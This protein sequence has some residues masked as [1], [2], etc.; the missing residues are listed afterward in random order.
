MADYRIEQPSAASPKVD[1][2]KDRRA[3]AYDCDDVE[4]AV[5]R[6]IRDRGFDREGDQVTLIHPDGYPER[7]KIR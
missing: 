7:L 4:E 6:I 3:F 1:I 5:A 2:T